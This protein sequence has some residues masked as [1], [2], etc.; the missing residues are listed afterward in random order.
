MPRFLLLLTLFLFTAAPLGAQPGELTDAE[1]AV[2]AR[3]GQD[4]VVVVHFWAPWCGNSIA[5]LR[6]G[7]YEIVEDEAHSDVDFIFVT[8]WNNGE[9]GRDVMTRFGLP[10]SLEERTQTDFGPSGERENRRRTFLGLPVTWIPTTWIFRPDG[11]LAYAFNYGEL[12]MET[13]RQ[14]IGD[15]RNAWTH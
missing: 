15:T 12:R 10:E 11:P 14:A 8:I 3:L 6:A 2:Q 4:R 7:W 13:L 1:R 5:E 9:S